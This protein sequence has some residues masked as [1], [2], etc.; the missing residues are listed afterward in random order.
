MIGPRKQCRLA[1]LL[2]AAGLPA[3]GV[4]PAIAISVENRTA[5]FPTAVQADSR[6]VRPGSLFVAYKGLV[7]DGHMFI[8]AA[9]RAGAIAVVAERPAD[10][11]LPVPL[12]LT[13]DAR[14]AWARLCAA[15][16]GFPSRS[17]RMAGV[18]GTDGKT[19]TASLLHHILNT[20]GLTTGL[21]ST[22]DARIGERAIDTGL[23]TTTPP[24]SQVQALLAEMVAAGCRAAVVEATSEGLA[25]RRLAACEFDLAILTNV[26]HDHL[27]FHGCFQAYRE[28]KATLFRYLATSQHKP[29][30]P[31][32]AILNRDDPS[33]DYFAGI[34]ADEHVSYGLGQADVVASVLASDD[35]GFHLRLASPWGAAESWLPLP[36]TFNAYNTAAA[37]AAACTWGVELDAALAAASSF[38]G[39]PG[40]MEFIRLGQPYNVIVDFA[41]T[42]NALEQALRAARSLTPARLIVVFGCAGERDV[43]K[44]QPM[45]RI[46]IELADHTVF[47]AEDPR[48]EDLGNIL[49]QMEQG[50]RQAGGAA[51]RQ[52][53]IVPD[54]A[55]AIVEAI[56]MAQPGDTVLLCGKGHEQSMCYDREERPWS[57]HGTVEAALLSLGYGVRR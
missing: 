19:T 34:E 27:Y 6:A 17:L 57:E 24:P 9:V 53:R 7:D 50:A 21:V 38:P 31:K 8:E 40:R 36:G 51:G 54:R 37:V 56:A 39:V 14:L 26:T 5:G 23:H 41:H 28:A 44:R 15:W 2:R 49:A 52:Y 35:R 55:A 12:I 33:Y 43:L 48:R 18:T 1:D 4:S 10:S 13:P 25:Q 47:T 46:A 11:P 32:V 30:L 22:V 29:G 3:D 20:S 42:S 16:E 45:A